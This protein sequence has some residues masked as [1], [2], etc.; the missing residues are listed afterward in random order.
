[1]IWNPIAGFGAGSA[2]P[3]QEFYPGDP[4][5][6]M[7]GNDIFASRAGSASRRISR[8]RSC[9]CSRTPTSGSADPC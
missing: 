1:V 6:D 9:A 5:V 8:A 7:V 2:R 3:A 4:Y